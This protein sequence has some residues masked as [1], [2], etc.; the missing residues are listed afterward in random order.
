MNLF[1]Y[2]S[3]QSEEIQ[4]LLLGRILKGTP[5]RLPFASCRAVL[6]QSYPAVNFDRRFPLCNQLLKTTRSHQEWMDLFK[7]Y[8]GQIESIPW[9]IGTVYEGLTEQDKSILDRYEGFNP[10]LDPTHPNQLYISHQAWVL[11][12]DHSWHQSWIYT[13]SS[14]LE[15]Q[16][17]KESYPC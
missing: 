14:H 15:T 17:G 12:Q 3:L 5:C 8:S 13:A 16:L 2:G 9:V 7:Q 1:C 10:H 11:T 6:N 4:V